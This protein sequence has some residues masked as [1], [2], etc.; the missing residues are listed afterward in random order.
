MALLRRAAVGDGELVRLAPKPLQQEEA[1]A[2]PGQ[3]QGCS[4]AG[5]PDLL[6]P[7]ASRRGRH[8]R[9]RTRPGPWRGPRPGWTTV[10]DDQRGRVRELAGSRGDRNDQQRAVSGRRRTVGVVDQPAEARVITTC[11]AAT[12][13][14]PS[15]CRMMNWRDP[16]LRGSRP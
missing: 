16:L 4:N 11:T 10:D 7:L 3:D 6:Q 12:S 1:L 14:W 2:G 9:C 13:F 5:E 8:R 15:T